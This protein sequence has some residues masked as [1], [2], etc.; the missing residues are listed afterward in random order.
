MFRYFTAL[1]LV[2]GLSNHLSAQTQDRPNVLFICVDDLRT[3]LGAYGKHYVKSP[4]ID[5]LA[6]TGALFTNHYVQVPTCGASRHAI[7][8]GMRPS[9]PIHLSNNSIVEEISG[10]PE[11]ETPETFIHRFKQDGYHTVGIGK[12]SHSADGLVYGY[13]AQPSEQRE[14]PHSWSELLFNPG[15]WKTGWN[16]FFAYANGENRQ[17]LK[18]QV[19][20][21]EA[22]ETDD[23]GYPDG[24]TAD[25]AISKLKELKKKGQPFFMGVGFF[26]P[27]LPFN[28]PKKY[29]DLYDE[30]KIPLS[31]NPDIPENVNLKSLHGS[32]EFN[33]YALGEEKAGLDTQVSDAY[34]R[35][36]RHGY[37][38]SI[39]YIDA[40]IGKLYQELKALELDKNT[41]IVIWGDH[42]WHLGD[43]RVW[44][45]H[46]L[47]ENALK[48]TLIINSPLP[49]HK[50]K[51]VRAIVESVDIY[52]TLLDMCGID[53]IKPT[54]GESFEKHIKYNIPDTEEVA[55]SYFRNG[56]S[57]RTKDYRLTKYFRKDQ[58]VIELYDHH[59]GNAIENKNIADKK[60]N[61]VKELMLLLNKGDTGLYNASE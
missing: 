16:S 39:S 59:K 1:Y 40:Q 43:Q 20:P 28:A 34:A 55:Y 45:K 13:E 5:A 35:K 26:K 21:Y 27:H 50:A 7:L 52:P 29:W 38:A 2:L 12:I 19:K 23:Q 25:L 48:S 44:G 3:E 8:T 11:K 6:K 33:Q 53:Q 15:K 37:L 46:T 61:T 47:F 41:I 24:L 4:H 56:I 57:M 9:K 14:L 30:N 42:G 60:P 31:P 10:Q 18:K 51:K 36:L 32:G 17:S 54:D 58:P 22:G 49:Q